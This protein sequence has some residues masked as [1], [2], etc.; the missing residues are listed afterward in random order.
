MPF[1]VQI[2]ITSSS[3]RPSEYNLLVSNIT[4]SMEFGLTENITF[5]T[6]YNSSIYDKLGYTELELKSQFTSS[7]DWNDYGQT[8]KLIGSSGVNNFDFT[9]QNGILSYYALANLRDTNASIE[10]YDKLTKNLPAD[11]DLQGP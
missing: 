6:R 4:S 10:G 1:T 8:W 5:G 2:D 7:R 11:S 9:T 3:L